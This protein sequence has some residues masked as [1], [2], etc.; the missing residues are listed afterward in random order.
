M[1]VQN[2]S[3]TKLE[4]KHLEMLF[5]ASKEGLWDMQPDGSVK[6][7]NQ[8]FYK[9]FEVNLKASTLTEWKALIHPEDRVSF[10]NNVSNQTLNGIED[11]VSEY[12]VRN[13]RGEFVWIE[14]KGVAKFDQQGKFEYMVGSHSNI[15]H[16]KN[17]EA[18]IYHLAY[19]DQLTG[20]YNRAMLVKKLIYEQHAQMLYLNLSKFRTINDTYGYERANEVL[21][22][23][24]NI[25]KV[26]FVEIGDVFRVDAD[27]FAILLPSA[28]EEIKLKGQLI[29]IK[30]QFQAA[31]HEL[32]TGMEIAINIGRAMHSDT[33]SAA[34]G[35][36]RMM[37]EAKWAMLYGKKRGFDYCIDYNEE[38]RQHTK[39]VLFIETGILNGLQNHEFYMTYQP[40]VSLGSERVAM[41]E[42][43]MRWESETFGMIMP[44]EFIPIAEKTRTIIK[45]GEFAL[46]SACQTVRKMLDTANVSIPISINISAIQLFDSSFYQYVLKTLAKYSLS[47]AHIIFEITESV[48]LDMTTRTIEVIKLFRAL[49][50]KIALDDFGS[51]YSSLA[52][53]LNIP[54]DFIKIDK[55]II[56]KMVMD[57][58]I[59]IFMGALMYLC[60]SK[61]LMVISEGIETAVMCDKVAEL[62]TDYLQ[63]FYYAKP[64][65]AAAAE[66]Y[67]GLAE[68]S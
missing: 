15:S 5:D 27:E 23:F 10:S 68:R 38:I 39:R 43:L 35:S 19:H 46:D 52:S 55:A 40:I 56:H 65:K 58:E 24:A 60:H 59:K 17:A 11:F 33:S 22:A 12:R 44:D 28:I 47:G 7:F 37:E 63:G 64:M 42:A 54:F 13:R 16:R 1:T 9:D 67:L 45:L 57:S 25:L 31:L 26:Y 50:I 14:A 53:I 6:F 41:M 8:N 32:G 48:A 61:G 4:L 30:E 18:Q 20:L 36:L 21:R 62:Q 34:D 49:G 29:L 51:G 3:F 2:N 66:A